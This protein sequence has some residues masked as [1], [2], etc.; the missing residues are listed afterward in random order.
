MALERLR[1]GFDDARDLRLGRFAQRRRRA[2]CARIPSSA[3]RADRES[4]NASRRHRSAPSARASASSGHSFASGWRSAS[5]SQIARLSHTVVAAPVL[6]RSSAPAR[7]RPANASGSLARAGRFVA[8]QTDHDFLERRAG[9]AHRH[10]GAQAPAR[11]VLGAE[12]QGV[13]AAMAF[14]RLR[15]EAAISRVAA[16][17]TQ[18]S[19]HASQPC[20]KR[21]G[22]RAA[23]RRR[24]Q[25]PQ[26]A[27]SPRA[28][29]AK[30]RS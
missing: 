18:R 30:R 10:I 20:S 19:S 12:D 23:A 6:R 4:R 16:R 22:C 11:P 3:G 1:P 5:V 14:L 9:R 8:A 29:N 2:G 24:R 26:G 15:A 25:R 13:G 27:F 7:G 17:Q 28:P 21:K